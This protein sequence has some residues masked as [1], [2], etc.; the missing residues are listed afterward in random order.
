MKAAREDRLESG[1]A[2][3]GFPTRHVLLILAIIAVGA[4]LWQTLKEQAVE[5]VPEPEVVTPVVIEAP[6]LPA[7][8]DI[9]ERTEPV[10]VETETEEVVE[11]APVLPP[12]EESDVL[13]R[14]QFAAAGAGPALEP[15]GQQENL[16]QQG[17]VLIDGFSRGEVLRKLLPLP[18]PAVAFPVEELD[19][20][21][22][23]NPQGYA[24]YNDYAESIAGLD[25]Q[26]VVNS[27]HLMRPLLEQ[28]YGQ[29]GLN[30]GDFDNAVVRTLDRILATPE[31]DE[32]IALTRKSVM[33]KYADPKL[34]QLAPI[35]KQL[36][37]MGPENIRR[38]K[39][40]AR[41]L[42]AGLLNQQ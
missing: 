42:R 11:V 37:R 24:R 8:E 19:G 25:T 31:I 28:A 41:A 10:V 18:A 5:T 2:S 13:V 40:Q 21:M 36:L 35:Q 20:Q 29:L 3:G 33:Y 9:P 17:V 4:V 27:F 30:P 32:P 23:M 22:Y 6:P 16:I 15:I 14:E 1:A 34:E 7:A 26:S 38:I 12:L 39:E